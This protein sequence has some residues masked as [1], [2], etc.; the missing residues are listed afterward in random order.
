MKIISEQNAKNVLLFEV[1]RQAKHNF[2]KTL[3]FLETALFHTT[4]ATCQKI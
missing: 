3:G 4:S 2:A 1:F